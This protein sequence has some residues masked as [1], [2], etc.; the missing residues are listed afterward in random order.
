M[1]WQL[2]RC[3]LR[4]LNR[5]A[6]AEA[7]LCKRAARVDYRARVTFAAAT[8]AVRK[9]SGARQSPS[10]IADNAKALGLLFSRLAGSRDAHKATAR[11]LGLRDAR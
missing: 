3:A 5:G 4:V 6:Q 10:A 1:L 11:T 8:P 7:R 9:V 2:R